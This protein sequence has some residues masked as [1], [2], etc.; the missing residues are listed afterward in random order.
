[1]S[2]KPA[3]VAATRAGAPRV[4]VYVADPRQLEPGAEPPA[5][6][7][8]AAAHAPP[9]PLDALYLHDNQPQLSLPRNTVYRTQIE[10]NNQR[11]LPN[12][13]F[14][15]SLND[16]DSKLSAYNPADNTTVQRN[17]FF[18]VSQQFLK[19]TT[20][21]VEESKVNERLDS[22][23]RDSCSQF[24]DFGGVEAF[25]IPVESGDSSTYQVRCSG[26]IAENIMPPMQSVALR[27]GQNQFESCTV[28]SEGTNCSEREL[29]VGKSYV[30]YQFLE[31]SVS[32]QS[33]VNQSISILNQQ[34]GV[35]QAVVREGESGSGPPQLVRT[36][37]GVVLAVLPSSVLPQQSENT[38]LITRT[39]I[40]DIQTII[41]PIGW[42]RIVNVNAVVY[43]SPSGTA[44]SNLPQLKEYLQTTGTCKCGL[45]CPLRP[46]TTF[47]FDPKVILFT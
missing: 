35:N 29:S 31:Q 47:S 42:R 12:T 19:E 41:V 22:V 32:H 30:N 13:V 2:G 38:E 44:L 34:V 36:A 39:A 43:V 11:N 27:P 33:I 10:Q 18:P 45:P 20:I 26:P 4:L 46:E 25:R 40:S 24:S 23:K 14:Y 15:K 7:A 8:A 16:Q 28:Q 5:P 9:P 6:P 37:D 21:K 17:E 1:M 3:S